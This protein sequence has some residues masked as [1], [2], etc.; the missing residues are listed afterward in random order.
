MRVDEE[1]S[2]EVEVVDDRSG[3][4]FYGENVKQEI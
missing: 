3:V 2:P 1:I 4:K